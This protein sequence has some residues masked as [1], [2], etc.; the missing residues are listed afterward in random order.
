M[1]C[2]VQVSIA[3]GTDKH[4]LEV[5]WKNANH[6]A[7]LRAEVEDMTFEVIATKQDE[8]NGDLFTFRSV[9]F[10]LELSSLLGQL[11]LFPSYV[12][13][14]P[15]SPLLQSSVVKLGPTVLLHGEACLPMNLTHKGSL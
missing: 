11:P 1:P 5:T 13:S 6:M 9:C 14:L 2:V 4:C 3:E 7:T 12:K 10:P 8:E 15:P